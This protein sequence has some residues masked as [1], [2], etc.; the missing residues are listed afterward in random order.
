M[1]TMGVEV[2][3]ENAKAVESE[4][5]M[6]GGEDKAGV[7]VK[8]TGKS[9]VLPTSKQLD[10]KEC[11]LVTFDLPYITFYYNQKLLVYKGGE[12]EER[13]EKLK[14]GLAAALEHFYPLAGKLGKDEEGVLRVE[15][16][17]EGVLGAEVLEAVA[18][19]VEVAELADGDAPSFLQ[20]LV[21]YSGVMNLEGL[22]RPLLAV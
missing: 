9:R 18:E 22:H 10:Q 1:M 3:V 6:N 2:E 21:P 12:Y 11:P 17:G 16:D 15:C 7:A 20:E 4:N 5:G 19:S 14:A 13:V 8:V